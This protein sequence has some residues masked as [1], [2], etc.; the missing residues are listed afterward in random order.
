MSKYA[1]S[2]LNVYWKQIIENDHTL[3]WIVYLKMLS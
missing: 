1:G 2:I 3:K